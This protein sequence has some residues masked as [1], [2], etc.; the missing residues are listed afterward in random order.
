MANS[1]TKIANEHYPIAS[2]FVNWALSKALERMEVVEYEGKLYH[3]YV[4]VWQGNIK[5]KATSIIN[6]IG[7]GTIFLKNTPMHQV[8]IENTA[9]HVNEYGRL[10]VSETLFKEAVCCR[11]KGELFD[12]A[13]IWTQTQRRYYQ[14]GLQVNGAKSGQRIQ[15][16]TDKY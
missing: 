15:M 10:A 14:S 6:E 7:T 4:K 5:R 8:W 1:D 16:W 11:C 9:K 13:M 12:S 3:S 2:R